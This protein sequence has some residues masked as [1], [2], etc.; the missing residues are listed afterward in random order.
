V[1]H[2]RRLLTA[3]L[4][5]VGAVVSPLGVGGAVA[6]PVADFDWTPK[7][8]VAGAPVSLIS[9]A[10]PE[11]API[12]TTRW[13]LD[14][15]ETCQGA[16][17]I[18]TF[19]ATGEWEVE[20][21]VEDSNGDQDS[22]RKTIPVLPAPP[23]EAPTAAFAALPT[24]PVAGEAVMFVSYSDDRDGRITGQAWDTDGDGAFDDGTG[25][26]AT[27]KFSVS[28]Q[29]TI[30]LRVVDDRGAVS[31]RS[32]AV[33]VRERLLSPFPIVRLSGTATPVGTRIRLL[34][35]SAPRGARAL[36]R[37]RG[38]GCPIK[39]AE[40]VVRGTAVRLRAVERVMP[41]GVVLDVLVRR[42]DSIGKFTRF[43]FRRSHRPRRTD[44]C[45]W[46]GTTRMARCPAA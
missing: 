36:V 3:C 9:T 10:T 18:T 15:R 45:L 37:C 17:C 4:L 11:D 44:G 40:T 12:A 1:S 8:V 46:P 16:T 22:A 13:M 14:G 20:L 32:F 39:R 5:A 30:S 2:V 42:G 6:D 27:R 41:P 31:T 38:E 19:P 29:K 34:S 7:P 25:P 35:V 24:S 21:E 28:G 23:N 43:R 26:I 33:L